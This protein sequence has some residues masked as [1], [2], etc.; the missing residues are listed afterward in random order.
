MDS[1]DKINILA[2]SLLDFEN[3][4]DELEFETEMLQLD[5]MHEIQKLM[6][7][8]GMKKSELAKKLGKL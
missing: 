5:I 3:D 2:K 8:S 1:Q 4:N 6:D 7:K